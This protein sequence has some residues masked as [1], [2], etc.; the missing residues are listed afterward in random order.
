MVFAQTRIHAQQIALPVV[1]LLEIFGRLNAGHPAEVVLADDAHAQVFGLLLLLAFLRVGAAFGAH[2]DECCLSVHFISGGSA[3]ADHERLG[4][5]AAERRQFA[6]KDD[7]LIG[8]RELWRLRGQRAS[9]V[10]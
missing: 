7:E 1:L 4:F 3:K 6:G 10:Q 2:D 9:N 5:L 8:Q